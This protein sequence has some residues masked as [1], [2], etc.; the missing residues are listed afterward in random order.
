MGRP[1]LHPERRPLTRRG[2]GLP[3]LELKMKLAELESRIKLLEEE[4][5]KKVDKSVVVHYSLNPKIYKEIGETDGEKK[6]V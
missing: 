5:D 6:T 4:M 3:I 1:P 2:K